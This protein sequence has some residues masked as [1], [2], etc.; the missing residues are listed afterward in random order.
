VYIVLRVDFLGCNRDSNKEKKRKNWPERGN[1]RAAVRYEH[2]LFR[3]IFIKY[4]VI[5]S[6]FYD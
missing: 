5:D 1:Q 4:K 3:K 2:G 6:C